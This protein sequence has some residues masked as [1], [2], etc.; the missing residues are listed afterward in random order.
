MIIGDVKHMYKYLYGDSTE[1]PLKTDFLRLLDN[2]IDTSVKA[3]NL[4][5]TI[6][7]LKENIKDRRRLRNSVLVE[8]D[9]FLL[10]VENAI[11]EAVSKSKE[12]ETIV[13]YAEKSK[14]FLNKFIT[15]GK[16]K[17]SD[18]IFQEI[19]QFEKQTEETD[20]EIINI[21][22]SFFIHD[23]IPIINK[24]YTIKIVKNYSIKIQV[25]YEGKISC[26]YIISP[27][28]IPFWNKTVKVSDFVEGIEIPIKMKKPFLKK[29]LEP[30]I[31]N[32]DD[33]ILYDLML[34][35]KEIEV[36][37]RKRLDY[38]GESCRLKMNLI[39]EYSIDVYYTEA[40]I[41]KNICTT[42]ELKDSL[43]IL[44]LRELGEE[45]IKQTE[46]LYPKRDRLEY[47]Y[48][49]NKDVIEENIVFELLQK[50][51]EIFVPTIIDIKEHSPSEEELSIK[52]ED[53]NGNRKEIYLKKS[54]VQDKLTKIKEKGDKLLEIMNIALKNEQI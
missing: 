28:E 22:E 13:K 34:S 10:T 42:P 20:N 44:R 39:E 19:I 33:Y 27:S 9:K 36:L 11:S 47:I 48:Y 49:D 29:E 41:E 30:E 35:G 6:F 24:I 2:F 31:V 5:N 26:M 21:L 38:S 8:M 46:S 43:N 45:I 18:D 37:F 1:S 15:D 17:F 16:V 53:E 7:D 25:D 50:I 3:I 14:D 52:E 54:Q 40:E 51:A 4:E 23:P 32:I 12:R